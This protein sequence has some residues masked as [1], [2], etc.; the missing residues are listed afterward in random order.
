LPRLQRAASPEAAAAV[1]LEWLQPGDRVLLK[2]SR[3]VALERAIPL[4]EA[5]LG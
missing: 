2:A 3:G 1:L 5:S 4:L